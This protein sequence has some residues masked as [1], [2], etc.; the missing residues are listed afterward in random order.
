MSET[1]A[2]IVDRG[3]LDSQIVVLLVSSRARDGIEHP[4]AE[5]SPVEVV[6]S[7]CTGALVPPSRADSV[8]N[9]A[10]S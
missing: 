4:P 2:F 9:A 10:E 8:L 5:G 3:D 6:A 1:G 7:M